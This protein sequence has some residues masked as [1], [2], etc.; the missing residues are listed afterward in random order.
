MASLRAA[1][2]RAGCSDVVT[3]VQSGNV[4]LSP[5]VPA[6]KN[7][8]AWLERVVS[9]A[10]GFDVPVVLRTPAE[11]ERTVSRNPYPAASGAQL[12]VVFYAAPPPAGLLD[13]IDV[14][15][16]APEECTLVGAELYLHLPSGMG[17]AKLPVE[18]ERS[19][20]RATSVPVATARNWNTVLKLVELA[21]A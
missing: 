15:A 1:L 18:L 12:H 8:P 10:A 11:L 19:G 21:H 2:E 20:R 5:P 14:A 3:Y 7:L 17:R 4:V 16:F 13:G 9:D 6:P